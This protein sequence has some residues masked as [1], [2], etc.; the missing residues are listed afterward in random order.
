MNPDTLVVI[1]AYAGDL[2]QI[3]TNLPAYLHHKCPVVV[4]SPEDAPITRVHPLVECRSAGLKGWI[5]LHTLERQKKFLQL[6]LT[7]PHKF[8]LLNDADSI[9]LSPAIPSYLYVN[10]GIFWSNEVLDT[11]PG[12]SRLP[13]IAVQPPYFFARDV[14]ERM[15]EFA[16]RPATSYVL[17][18]PH[19]ALPVPTECIDHWMLQ[20]IYAAGISHHNFRDGASFE[21]TSEHGLS[22]MAHHIRDQGK[23]FIHQVKTRKVFARVT[24]DYNWRISRRRT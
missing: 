8:F 23:I 9:C 7:Y 20:V 22:T 12:E 11:N 3:T 6:M 10:K 15:V 21:T 13:K 17:P 5:G 2:G 24:S 4:M 1:S 18:T 19:G 16:D 14:L